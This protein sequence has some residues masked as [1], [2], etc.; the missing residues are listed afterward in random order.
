M[1]ISSSVANLVDLWLSTADGVGD[2]WRKL[3]EINSRRFF[4]EHLPDTPVYPFNTRSRTSFASSILFNTVQRH[5]S[6]QCVKFTK[7]T[8]NEQE[9]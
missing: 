3:T 1:F 5:W 2:E 8:K 6:K 9:N 4:D 7:L